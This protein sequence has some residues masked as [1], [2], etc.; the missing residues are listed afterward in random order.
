MTFRTRCSNSWQW[1]PRLSH[2][3]PSSASASPSNPNWEYSSR[4]SPAPRRTLRTT[5]IRENSRFGPKSPSRPSKYSSSGRGLSPVRISGHSGHTKIMR[6]W[7]LRS[8]HMIL[9]RA[10]SMRRRST[11]STVRFFDY[12]ISNCLQANLLHPALDQIIQQHENSSQT[13]RD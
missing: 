9:W 3:S 6:L 13:T 11:S 5:S 10:C 7:R 12:Y 8:N 1:Q 2:S 4:A